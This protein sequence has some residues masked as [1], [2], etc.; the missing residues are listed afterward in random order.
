MKRPLVTGIGELL[1]DI[2]PDGRRVGGAPANFAY[3]ARQQGADAFVVS[4]AGTDADGQAIFHELK[5]RGLSTEYIS[6]VPDHHTGTVS[7]EL[8]DGIPSYTIH[9]PVAWDFIP[10]SEKLAELASRTDAVC[11]GTLAQRGEESAKTIRRFLLNTRPDCLKM[12]DINLRQNFFSAD[13]IKASLSICDFLKISDEEF[14]IVAE[15]LGIKGGADIVAA[16]LINRY[17]LK[18]LALSKGA[19]GSVLYDGKNSISVSAYD[20]GPKVDTVGCG[21]SFTAALVSGLLLNVSPEKSM[22]HASK[23][24]GLVCASNGAMPEVP[25]E[26][27]ICNKISS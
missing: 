8:T 26:L 10:F 12:L 17:D 18:Y 16:E 1:W 15:I 23:V 11:F 3:H 5:S 21:D 19:D 7:V 2:L 25:E 27:K 22:L 4:A 9:A 14:P 13:L 6:T 20:H 24:A